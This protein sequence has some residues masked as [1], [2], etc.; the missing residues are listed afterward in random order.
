MEAPVADQPATPDA[1]CTL[2]ARDLSDRGWSVCQNFMPPSVVSRLASEVLALRSARG[3][4][5]AAVGTGSKRQVRPEIRQDQVRWIDETALSHAQSRYFHMLERLRQALNRQLFLGLYS[6]E[7]HATVYEPG[8]FYLKHLD[9]FRDAQDRVVS[10]ILYLN[11]DWQAQ[12]CGQLRLYLG[13]N[14]TD[15]HLDVLPQGGTLAVFLSERFHHEVLPARRD[16]LSITGWF[17]TRN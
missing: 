2:I 10:C 6:F 11:E 16:R 13:E 12:D 1:R 9:Q 3:L 14:G 15:P 17:K 7:G 5:P 4:R 8:T